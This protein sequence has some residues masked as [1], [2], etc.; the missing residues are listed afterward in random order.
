VELLARFIFENKFDA[1]GLQIAV[2]GEATPLG[3]VA[4]VGAALAGIIVPTGLKSQDG[5]YENALEAALLPFHLA[6]VGVGV[7][8]H[9]LA[10]R[11]AG[12]EAIR[13]IFEVFV[14]G[15]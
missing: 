2:H 6:G 11:V 1:L 15:I 13:E 14:T 7:V 9:D 8:A 4:V 3:I 10:L 5:L 12:S